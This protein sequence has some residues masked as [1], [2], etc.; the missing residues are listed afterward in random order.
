MAKDTIGLVDLSGT[1]DTILPLNM[2]F[3]YTG[4]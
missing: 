2:K 1:T 3:I 4:E